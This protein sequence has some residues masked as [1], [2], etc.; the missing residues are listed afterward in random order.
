MLNELILQC[1]LLFFVDVLDNFVVFIQ[2]VYA[3]HI[4]SLNLVC[5][6]KPN[7]TV[8]I[9]C[10]LTLH[11]QNFYIMHLL[12]KVTHLQTLL[13]TVAIIV[14]SLYQFYIFTNCTEIVFN[15]S[16]NVSLAMVLRH[17]CIKLN[18][19]WLAHS[20]STFYTCL[21]VANALKIVS[22]V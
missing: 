9:F 18:Y 15:R 2:F 21:D 13:D 19:N 6:N 7:R 4:T 22:V 5:I 1:F 8:I 11:L 20:T 10:K 12:N 16:E 17:R 3:W 14:T